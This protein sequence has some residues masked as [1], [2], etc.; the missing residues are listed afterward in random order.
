M[1]RCPRFG[2]C[3]TAEFDS[4]IRCAIA[5][6]ACSARPTPS[7]AIR[8]ARKT[9]PAGACAPARSRKKDNQDD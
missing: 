1:T 8:T 2:S 5:L 6:V 9:K 3:L 4:E 7:D